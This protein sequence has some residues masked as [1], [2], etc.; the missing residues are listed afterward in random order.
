M[1]G[2]Q[3]SL[4][5]DPVT[6]SP[7]DSGT[8]HEA[9]SKFLESYTA[10]KDRKPLFMMIWTVD[11]HDPYTPPTDFQHKFDIDSFSPV[12][13]YDH[14]LLANLKLNKIV[15]SESN[16]E[17]IRTRYD[18]EIYFN[19][20]SFG[21]L[22]EKLKQL[23]LY[24]EATV[25]ITSDHGEEFFDHGGYGHGMTLY[26]EQ[27]NVPLVIKTPLILPGERSERVQLADI[28]PSIIDMLGIGAPYTLSGDSIL[29]PLDPQRRIHFEQRQ[30][31]NDLIGLLDDDAIIIVNKSYNRMPT[32][33]RLPLYEIY[34]L[35]DKQERK[36]ML[37]KNFRKQLLVQ[38]VTSFIHKPDTIG[39]R[40]IEAEIT[41]E[42][43]QRLKE[44]GYVK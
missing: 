43:D 13:T 6:K 32:R 8:V 23:G 33:K 19:D 39:A 5:K 29:Q 25:V 30:D 21:A 17:F 3:L 20:R 11:P 26:H 1:F 4:G 12:D 44:L 10:K 27:V 18:Q 28:Y 24:D 15:P 22:L 35:S 41:P 38:N 14:K 34:D 2:R 37:S 42:I 16:L 36:P 9:V 40:K 7:V 31:G